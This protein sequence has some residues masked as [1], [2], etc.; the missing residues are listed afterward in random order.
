MNRNAVL[1]HSPSRI[2]AFYDLRLPET[3]IAQAE[4]ATHYWI[5]ASTIRR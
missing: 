4:L 5:E 1:N 2:I 3:R